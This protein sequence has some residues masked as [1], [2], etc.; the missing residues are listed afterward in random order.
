M[1]LLK[2]KTHLNGFR[3]RTLEVI[4]EVAEYHGAAYVYVY[5]DWVAI[6]DKPVEN[7]ETL[8]LIE[9]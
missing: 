3:K 5:Y 8:K 7:Y 4:Q 1:F 6:S 2:M 9:S